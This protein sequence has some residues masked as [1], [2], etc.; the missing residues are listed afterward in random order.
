MICLYCVCIYILYIIQ[1][2][3]WIQRQQEPQLMTAEFLLWLLHFFLLAFG[4]FLLDDAREQKFAEAHV[5]AL[6][7]LVQHMQKNHKLFE[8]DGK[9]SIPQQILLNLRR[10]ERKHEKTIEN[11]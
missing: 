4:H 10:L 5:K 3:P 11:P 6:R 1:L 2:L 9:V 8:V 7:R